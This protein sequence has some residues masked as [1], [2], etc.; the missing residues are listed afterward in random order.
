MPLPASG[1]SPKINLRRLTDSFTE[2]NNADG[3]FDSSDYTTA[4]GT[5]IDQR[6][7][8]P[9]KV[10]GGLTEVDVTPW[11]NYW[12]ANPSKNFGIKMYAYNTDPVHAWSGWSE[13]AT[14]PADRPVVVLEYEF[15]LTT[16]DTPT[17]LS[18]V[19]AVA[20]IDAFQGDFT[21]DDTRDTLAKTEI[22]V[23]PR[24]GLLD[25]IRVPV[26]PVADR[27]PDEVRTV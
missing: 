26:E 4:S 18:P 21:D 8:S 14:T 20:S 23:A 9:S 15:G 25:G 11:I 27:R 22:E 13:D 12:R 10:A 3:D 17:N 5:S 6:T 1:D 24:H 7:V 16:P 2:G 19:G